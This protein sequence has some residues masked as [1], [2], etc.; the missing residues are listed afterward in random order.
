MS[1]AEARVREG[2]I[3]R[4]LC[5]ECGHVHYGP[6]QD[7]RCDCPC[8]ARWFWAIKY[9]ADEADE[10]LWAHIRRRLRVRLRP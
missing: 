10:S 8:E 1:S 9:R 7:Y 5:P 4:G 6:D 2:Y 3:Q